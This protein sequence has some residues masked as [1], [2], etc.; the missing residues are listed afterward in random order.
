MFCI[1]SSYNSTFVFV[2]KMA[3]KIL[4]SPINFFL[5]VFNLF[6]F[7][8][9]TLKKENVVILISYTPDKEKIQPLCVYMFIYPSWGDFSCSHVN[10]QTYFKLSSKVYVE[11]KKSKPSHLL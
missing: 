1:G 5:P 6:L 2:D 7:V 3:E 11:I 4:T 8:C 9:F 10:T